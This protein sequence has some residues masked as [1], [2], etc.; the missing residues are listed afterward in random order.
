MEDDKII[1]TGTK[2]DNIFTGNGHGYLNT[3]TGND[4]V[5]LGEGDFFGVKGF[6]GTDYTLISKEAAR[7]IN[8][9]REKLGY[10]KTDYGQDDQLIISLSDKDNQ[11]VQSFNRGGV[12][13][14]Q[15]YDKTQDK[16]I[17]GARVLGKDFEIK[18]VVDDEGLSNLKS[19][20][21]DSKSN[22]LD[23]LANNLND[24]IETG[25]VD[26]PYNELKTI[27]EKLQRKL[28]NKTEK[29]ADLYRK[30]NNP[31]KVGLSENYENSK[32]RRR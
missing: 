4:A 22:D 18:I 2:E 20:K 3:K 28:D 14:V 11:E 12:T 19:K 31:I 29:D 16:I 5:V 7:R 8:K 21:L 15:I 24:L 27:G 30:S 17:G 23:T 25:K 9:A 32:F 10:K 1:W 26:T 13:Y 6:E